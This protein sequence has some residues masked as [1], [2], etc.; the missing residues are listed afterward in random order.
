MIAYLQGKLVH[1]EATYVIVEVG[2]IGYAVHISLNTYFEIKDKES[3][4][5]LTYFHVRENAQLLYGFATEAEKLMFQTLN[6]VN[7]V[8]AN[9]AMLIL[10]ALSPSDLKNAVIQEDVSRIQAVKGIGTKTA[11]RIILELKDKL[12]KFED[13]GKMFV[14]DK[15]NNIRKEALIALTTLGINRQIAEKSISEIIKKSD[16]NINLEE[17]VKQAIRNT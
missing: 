9:T 5:L 12:Q 15:S 8:G 4:R 17:L 6:T 3:V 1:K 2:G 10:S 14:G 7:G 11:N 13:D 16:S